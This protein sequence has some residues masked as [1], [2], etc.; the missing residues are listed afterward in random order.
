MLAN[1]NMKIS[2]YIN[3][4]NS[5]DWV[6][7]FPDLKGC[8]AVGSTP[9][10]ALEQAEVAKVLWLEE[11]FELHGKYPV[12]SIM[13]D[14][15]SGKFL[16][17]V[18]KSLHKDLALRAENEGVSLNTLC[19]KILAEGVSPK[20]LHLSFDFTDLKQET[21]NNQWKQIDA[22]SR[23]VIPMVAS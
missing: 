5:I 21:D 18:P 17:R 13:Q 10:E 15:Y 6:V 4:N 23:K 19:I 11:Y 12:A 1:Y 2:Q 14:S 16:L 9:A 7:E 3:K 20:Q 22:T 8:S